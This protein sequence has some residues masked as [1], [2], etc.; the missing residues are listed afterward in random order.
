[1][2]FTRVI[3]RAMP[4]STKRRDICATDE[5]LMFGSAWTACFR[6]LNVRPLPLP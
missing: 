4:T 1:M 6:T 3:H 5:S 2:E